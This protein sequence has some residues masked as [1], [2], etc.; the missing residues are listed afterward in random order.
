M[1]LTVDFRLAA[2]SPPPALGTNIGY[3]VSIG[4]QPGG[5]NAHCWQ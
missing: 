3:E 2:Y 4:S 1:L 5:G